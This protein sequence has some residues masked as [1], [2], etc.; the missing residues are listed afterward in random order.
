M[1]TAKIVVG[2]DGSDHSA[3][4]L[5]W[6][7]DHADAFRAEVVVVH[8]VEIPV[9]L[10]SLL[11]I[12]PLPSLTELQ[13]E[14]IRDLVVGV[15]CKPLADAGVSYRVILVEGSAPAALARIAEA[16]DAELVVT[17][18]RGRGEFAELVLGSTSHALTHCLKRP[19]VIVP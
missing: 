6:C 4:G 5:Q 2:V 12:A 13:R 8:V 9:M 10:G 3:R 18:R 11:S 19:L 17:G 14:E 16:E 7:A 1:P 15:W